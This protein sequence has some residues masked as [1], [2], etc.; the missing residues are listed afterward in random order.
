GGKPAILCLGR[1]GFLPCELWQETQ[2]QVAHYVEINRRVALIAN[3]R[4]I[5]PLQEIFEVCIAINEASVQAF[6]KLDLPA[7]HR[8]FAACPDGISDGKS[9][10]QA[11]P[12]LLSGPDIAA[13][14]DAMRD[15][16]LAYLRQ[17]VPDLATYSD[18]I[19]VDLGYS[20]TIQR[21]LRDVFDRSG[22][23]HRLHGVYLATVDDSLI[24][25]PEGDSAS[26]FLDSSVIPPASKLFLLRNIAIL[27]Q[28]FSAPHG[29]VRRY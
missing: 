29:S 27:E 26:G 22:L 11:L 23:Q 28:I 8:Y 13:L 9:F 20:G 17:A 21:A 3:L 14:A 5:R 25:L 2:D 24:D 7:I 19:L 12:D 6:L 15:D 1:D 16:L 4:A 10:A 18:L